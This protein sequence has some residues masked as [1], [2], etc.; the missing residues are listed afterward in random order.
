MSLSVNDRAERLATFRW[1]EVR[2]MET[3]AAWTPTTPE[4]ELKVLLGRHIW[5][6]AQHADALGKRTFELRHPEQYARRPGEAY[7]ALVD[8]VARLEPTPDRLAALYDVLVPG[9]ARRYARYLDETDRLLDGPS[10]VVV[11]R[12]LAD[13]GRQQADAARVR[14]ELGLPPREAE[15]WRGREAAIDEL[16]APAPAAT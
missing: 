13:L 12:I 7:V 10:V 11:E 4:L 8:E 5:D 9:L 1:V 3:A 6:F 16:L 15:P 14:A 2:L